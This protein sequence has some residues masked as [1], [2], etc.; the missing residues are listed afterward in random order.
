LEKLAE[1]RSLMATQK[2]LGIVGENGNKGDSDDANKQLGDNGR[3]ISDAF[4]I[5]KMPDVVSA[6]ISPRNPSAELADAREEIKSLRSKLTILEKRCAVMDKNHEG[7]KLATEKLER[8]VRS[9]KREIEQLKRDLALARKAE[10]TMMRRKMSGSV[11]STEA[12]AAVA[13]MR[14]NADP[15][16]KKVPSTA[17]GPKSEPKT[18]T[19]DKESELEKLRKQVETAERERDNALKF[20]VLMMRKNARRQKTPGLLQGTSVVKA[21][22]EEKSR[23]EDIVAPEPWLRSTGR[24]MSVLDDPAVASRSSAWV[25]ELLL[26]GPGQRKSFVDIL[27]GMC[28]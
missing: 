22:A 7:R 20:A 4:A 2:A 14:I 12:A 16:E 3:K 21:C 8:E 17:S 18:Q 25:R 11:G 5:S 24:K 13:K 26:P 9:S 15:N 1:R 10:M 19:S 23:T 6:P 28:E 27:D